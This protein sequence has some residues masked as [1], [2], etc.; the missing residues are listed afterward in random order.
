MQ[1]QAYSIGIVG[2]TGLVGQAL[3]KLLRERSFPI[4]K[5]KLFASK[6]SAGQTLN[7]VLVETVK[8][9][10][11]AELDGV[12]F[13]AGSEVSHELAPQALAQGC[14]VIDNSSAFRMNPDVPLVVPEVNPEAL[15]GGARLIANPNCSTIIALMA[16][17]PLHKVFRLRECV[18]STYQAVSGSGVAATKALARELGAIA[19]GEETGALHY[20]H[21]IAMNVIPEVDAFL[22][23]G[24]TR[25]EEKM[26]EES[27]K[28]LGLPE[29]RV[30]TTCV[31]VPV[32][33]AHSIAITAGF[34]R[35]VSR[36]IAEAI[37]A[38]AP[39]LVFCKKPK[40]YPTPL[41]ASLK[42]ECYAGRL[43]KTDVFEYGLALWVVGDQ[44]WKG[45]A[46]NAIQIAE[47]MVGG[48]KKRDA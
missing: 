36:E 22:K 28:I 46:L 31:R 40:D 38:A 23:D 7:G 3:R 39:G 45:A 4:K 17:A 47:L 12:F 37:L 44:I 18:A 48:V 27:R 29:L 25:E 14:W 43:R 5:L 21:P 19:M 13:C 34:E 11:F 33:R 30:A 26:T 6:R 35:P 41:D 9:H 24:S 16:L 8:P 1:K 10:S 32:A 20:R 15:E 42:K 2:A